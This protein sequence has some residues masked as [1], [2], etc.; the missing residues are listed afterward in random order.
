MGGRAGGHHVSTT[1]MPVRRVLFTC[2]V[3]L[4]GAL[5]AAL[6]DTVQVARIPAALGD[7]F[8]PLSA[9]CSEIPPQLS[10]TQLGWRLGLRPWVPAPLGRL[11]R[12]C[13]ELA[14]QNGVRGQEGALGAESAKLPECP[15]RGGRD[16]GRQLPCGRAAW[17]GE[18][19]LV[20]CAPGP[21][22]SRGRTLRPQGYLLS[23]S[24]AHIFCP[25]S[26]DSFS[27]SVFATTGCGWE[28]PPPG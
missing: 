17:R 9:L 10:F 26:P 12:V 16:R 21:P 15:S 5:R 28:G 11:S 7:S 1:C 8:P 3:A 23:C 2:F 18:E 27:E 22:S 13:G 19:N 20:R 4:A 6:L 14:V 24:L 25:L